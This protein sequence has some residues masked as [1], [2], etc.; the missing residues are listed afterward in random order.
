[1]SAFPT[2]FTQEELKSLL[3]NLHTFTSAEQAQLLEI[4]DELEKRRQAEKCRTN[5]IEF[6]KHMMPDYKVGPHHK[7]LAQYLE[8]LAYGRKDR[9]TVSIAPR[10][11][12]S[13]L[14]S[15]FFPAWFIGNWP[16]KKI[17]IVSHTADLA[18]DFGRKVRNLINSEE[19][20][21]IFQDVALAADS[22]SAGRWNTNKGGE[23]FAVG[24]GGALAGRGAHLLVV[25]DPHNEQEILNGNFEIFEKAHEWYAYGARTRLM[26][27]GSVAI[28]AT[29]WAEQDLI[30][31]V[32]KD[33]IRN[34]DADQWDVVE[35][36]ALRE[37]KS[38]SDEDP[39]TERFIS[40]WPEQWSLES[41]LRT[42]ATMAPFR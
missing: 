5:L 37:K 36:P 29:R 16:D 34:P 4:I 33:M 11:G 40:L 13:Q 39:E 3:D 15:I 10:F 19:Y 8:D 25:D 9:I 31:Q 6:A 26:P 18:V 2:S 38:S 27:G 1:M 12:K 24:V 30:G 28:V 17:M 22:K 21:E 23:F 7:Q 32:Q 14:T 20:K 41:I 42:T 35:F